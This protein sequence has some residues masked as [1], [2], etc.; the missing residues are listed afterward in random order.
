M[1]HGESLIS[2]EKVEKLGQMKSLSE[3]KDF[4]Y[5]SVVCMVTITSHS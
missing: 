1:V 5:S 4:K 3:L 2:S